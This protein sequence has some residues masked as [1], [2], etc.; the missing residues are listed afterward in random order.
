MA[1]CHV[2][3]RPRQS[4][5]GACNDDAVLF[6]DDDQHQLIAMQLRF[7]QKM[8]PAIIA[9]LNSG[10]CRYLSAIYLSIPCSLPLLHTHARRVAQTVLLCDICRYPCGLHSYSANHLPELRVF[11]TLTLD[12]PSRPCSSSETRWHQH[13]HFIT[14]LQCCQLNTGDS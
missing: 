3:V 13:S 8:T 10:R 11:V 12:D 5:R 2:L 4:T 1:S 6:I 7:T 9:I 14:C